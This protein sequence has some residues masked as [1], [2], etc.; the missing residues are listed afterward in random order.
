MISTYNRN[1]MVQHAKNNLKRL[2][3]AYTISNVTAFFQIDD[4]VGVK[5]KCHRKRCDYSAQMTELE[6]HHQSCGYRNEDAEGVRKH[7]EVS[8]SQEKATKST[9]AVAGPDPE[10]VRK[11]YRQRFPQMTEEQ[12]KRAT[13]EYFRRVKRGGRSLPQSEKSAKQLEYVEQRH[14]AQLKQQLLQEGTKE[15]QEKTNTADMPDRHAVMEKERD[16][17]ESAI[18]EQQHV[19]ENEQDLM[20]HRDEVVPSQT[21]Q[22]RKEQSDHVDTT[23]QQQFLSQLNLTHAKQEHQQRHE[24]EQ[25]KRNNAEGNILL[26]V[27]HGFTLMEEEARSSQRVRTRR[28]HLEYAQQMRKQQLQTNAAQLKQGQQQRQPVEGDEQQ[29]SKNEV[30]DGTTINQEEEVGS[31]QRPQMSK[32]QSDYIALLQQQQFFRQHIHA[33]QLRQQQQKQL[34]RNNAEDAQE[35]ADSPPKPKIPKEQLFYMALQ[36]QLKQQQQQQERERQRSNHAEGEVQDNDGGSSPTPRV[37]QPLKELRSG[38]GQ[39]TITNEPDRSE[40]QSFKKMA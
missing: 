7:V 16:S 38:R 8:A 34:K 20:D 18:Q 4:A 29:K 23:R 31:S 33:A 3:N 28:E 26:R 27:L 37:R 2:K 6:K 21:P 36:R 11:L 10:V 30:L 5:V 19:Q 35:E 40:K 1:F 25:Q 39:S 32:D 24:E 15:E 14:D 22:I 13:V 17:P 9:A 12:V